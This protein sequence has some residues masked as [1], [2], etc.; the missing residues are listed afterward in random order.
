MPLGKRERL[1]RS[2]GTALE[3]RPGAPAHAAASRSAPR[4]TR[5]DHAAILELQATAGNAATT[6]LLELQRDGAAVATAPPIP[7]AP[8]TAAQAPAKTGQDQA[9]D[10]IV[11]IAGPLMTAPMAM[12]TYWSK[13]HAQINKPK[14][15]TKQG[16]LQP[17]FTDAFVAEL[18]AVP[19]A[20]RPAL[21]ASVLDKLARA[22]T[23]SLSSGPVSGATVQAEYKQLSAVVP[24]EG[25]EGGLVAMRQAVLASFGSIAD[26]VTYYKKM[27]PVTFLGKRTRGHPDLAA[28]LKTA[29]DVLD[30]RKWRTAAEASVNKVSALN[31]RENR[32]SPTQLSNHSFGTAVDISEDFNPNVSSTKVGKKMWPLVQDVMGEDVFAAKA[33][34]GNNIASGNVDAVLGEAQR[35]SKLSQDWQAIFADS[36]MGKLKTA[37]ITYAQTK[38]SAVK[39]ESGDQILADAKGGKT[40]DLANLLFPAPV[41]KGVKPKAAAKTIIHLYSVFDQAWVK[42]KKGNRTRMVE[43]GAIGTEGSIAAHGFLNLAPEVVA[44]CSGSDGGGLKWLG[45]VKKGTKDFMHFELPKLPPEIKQ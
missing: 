2:A 41:A 24:I 37:M 40:D 3:H 34:T 38:G 18:K 28:A 30:K 8:P 35:L 33:T 26:A 23:A 32:N 22:A 4:T 27:V 16:G 39:A 19:A 9:A 31:L 7:G 29:E 43:S 45:G 12:K 20:E 17:L 25:E 15:K 6:R 13:I 10:D 1:T 36:T 14:I 42:D 5:P 44:A 11:A 21:V